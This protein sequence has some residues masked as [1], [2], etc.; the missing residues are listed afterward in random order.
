[1]SQVSRIFRRFIPQLL[2]MIALPIFYFAFMLIYRPNNSVM[3]MG[4]DWFAVHLTISSCIL[5]LCIILLRLLYYF[6]RMKINYALYISWCLVEIIFVSFFVAL[7]LWLALDKP[8]LYFEIFAST[9][10]YLSLT[11]VFP[12]VI[13][14]LSIRLYD[15]HE[16]KNNPVEN[17]IQ[18]MRFY[19]DRHNLKIVLT[20]EAVLYITAEEN[21]VNIFYNENG[22]VRNYVLR[23][24]MKALDELCQE[25][26]LIRCHRSYFV[27]PSHV[28]VL[29]KDKDGIVYAE[30]D[31]SDIMHI[32]VTKRYYDR[33]S[34]ML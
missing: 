19:D 12:Y 5:L 7:Y 20:P 1:M 17:T 18:R 16:M 4:D 25:N 24:S 3:F 15:Y 32:P 21:Y 30:L 31:A 10:K 14:A 26:G 2:H 6:L 28:K 13:L 34:E 33:L 29:R 27:N 23:S 8:Q 11:L 9:F 22:K